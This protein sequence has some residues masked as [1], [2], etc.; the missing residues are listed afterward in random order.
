[1]TNRHL[2][3]LVVAG[4]TASSVLFLTAVIF[5]GFQIWFSP[6]GVAVAA[7][8]V[9]MA[10]SGAAV[11]LNRHRTR[12]KALDQVD[13]SELPGWVRAWQRIGLLLFALVMAF[14]LPSFI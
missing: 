5:L 7:G 1:M 2:T 13:P 14:L 8:I 11:S 9:I 10:F 12:S 3:H 6:T 4:L